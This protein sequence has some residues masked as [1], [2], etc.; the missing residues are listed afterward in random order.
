MIIKI[1]HEIMDFNLNQLIGQARANKFGSA[2]KKNKLMRDLYFQIKPQVSEFLCGKYHVKAK[3]LVPSKN[4]DLDNLQLKAILDCMQ[5]YGM[6]IND[7]LNHIVS[8]SHE[9]ELVKK[10]QQGVII[11]F[12][13][14]V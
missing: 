8:I 6:L 1:D 11:E 13:E 12:V 14:V 7:N 4:R 9:F 5:D 10:N 2:A 3:W